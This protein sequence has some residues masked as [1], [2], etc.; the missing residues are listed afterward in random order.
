MN[1][2]TLD[3]KIVDIKA[4]WLCDL[5]SLCFTNNMDIDNYPKETIDDLFAR[6]L[7]VREAYI[8]LLSEPEIQEDDN[9]E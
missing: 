9:A 1:P 3:K 6:G 4:N 5:N 7:T 2:S 8:E